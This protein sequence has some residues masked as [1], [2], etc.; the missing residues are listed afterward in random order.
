MY[1]Y[2][3]EDD[4]LSFIF[5]LKRDTFKL[6]EDDTEHYYCK[7]CKKKMKLRSFNR[8]NNSEDHQMKQRFFK[9]NNITDQIYIRLVD[10]FEAGK[11]DPNDEN[12]VGLEKVNRF[13]QLERDCWEKYIK[14]KMHGYFN[15][16]HED[17]DLDFDD[18]DF[19]YENVIQ[20]DQYEGDDFI[21]I[22]NGTEYKIPKN[23]IQ[24]ECNYIKWTKRVEEI[25]RKQK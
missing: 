23:E 18:Y 14:C 10:D 17:D 6:D 9:Q 8:H 1:Y 24:N 20:N 3:M 25:R 13:I 22:I 12:L 4:K 2:K 16:Y 5:H 11:F 7:Y 19:F 21:T 15:Q